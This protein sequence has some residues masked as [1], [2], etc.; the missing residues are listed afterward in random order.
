MCEHGYMGMEMYMGMEINNNKSNIFNMTIFME[1]VSTHT[2]TQWA[3][4]TI[5]N[6]SK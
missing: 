4:K 3:F 6:A 2:H 1:C 5:L